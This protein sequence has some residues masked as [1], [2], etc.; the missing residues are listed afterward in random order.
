MRK[1]F[2]RS[3]DTSKQAGRL[4]NSREIR[5]RY[6]RNCTFRYAMEHA[7]LTSTPKFWLDIWGKQDES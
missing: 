6:Y 3:N 2:S 1:G 7:L 5:D 4:K